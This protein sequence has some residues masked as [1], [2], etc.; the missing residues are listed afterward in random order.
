L[1]TDPLGLAAGAALPL[2]ASALT[3]QVQLEQL[4]PGVTLYTLR[5]GVAALSGAW[6]LAGDVVQDDAALERVRDCFT[7]LGLVPRVSEYAIAGAEQE[8][9]RIVTGGAWPSRAAAQQAARPAGDCRLQAR[10]ADGESSYADGPWTIHIVAI[11]PGADALASGDDGSRSGSGGAGRGSGGGGS[12][13]GGGGSG[14]SGGGDG[15]GRGWRVAANGPGPGLRARTSELSRSKGAG[16]AAGVA[17]ALF[18][19]NGGFF[20]VNEKD[21][22]PGQAAG[23]SLLAGQPNGAPVAGRPAVVLPDA[24]GRAPV[25]VRDFSWQASLT[26]SDGSTT[27]VDGINR[28]QGKVRNCGRHDGDLAIHDHTCRYADDVVYYPPDSRY[29]AAR[30]TD[31]QYA[32]APD[33]TVR[34][35]AANETP[36]PGDALLAGG[37]SPRAVRIGQQATSGLTARFTLNTSLTARYGAR[38][39][40]VNAGPMLLENGAFVRRD[41]Q[42]GWAMNSVDDAAHRMLMHD[43]INRRNPRTALGLRRDGTVLAVVVDG[44]QAG[45]VGLTIEELRQLMAALGAE[46]AVNLDGGGSSALVVR[47]RLVSTPSD[48]EGERK[49]GDALLF[50]APPR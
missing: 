14:G 25:I 24:P 46:D 2:G 39:S 18:A 42:E 41:A 4:A 27:P 43:W 36:R 12:G 37:G 44:H 6:H 49:V 9:Y 26:W 21:G 11:A 28:T 34:T 16:A 8:I 29:G 35:L 33:G 19:I 17:P 32:L 23:V 48:K 45:S 22:V 50:D 30:R 47:G 1:P 31:V 3:Q 7:Q 10:Q 20:V 40:V 13:S 15:R 38:A 5:R